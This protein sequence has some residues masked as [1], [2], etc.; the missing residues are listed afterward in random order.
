MPQPNQQLHP[1]YQALQGSTYQQPAHPQ[2]GYYPHGQS[3]PNYNHSG[4]SQYYPPPP[5]FNYAQQP[6]PNAA[7]TGKTPNQGTNPGYQAPHYGYQNPNQSGYTNYAP[8]G[9]N[10]AG[11]NPWGQGYSQPSWSMGT[12]PYP[13]TGMAVNPPLPFLATLDLPDVSKLT[14]D[15]ISHNPYWPPVPTKI[16]G[17]CPKFEGKAGE[18]P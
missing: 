2:S 5:G 16:P 8:Y 3:Q 10:P 11:Q 18:D 14:N 4:G 7:Y 17:D 1:T 6:N 13:G 12:G 9:Q 15:P